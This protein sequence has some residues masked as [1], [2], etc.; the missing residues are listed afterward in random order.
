[1]MTVPLLRV[2]S[3]ERTPLTA[4]SSSVTERAQCWHVIPV[5]VTV[6]RCAACTVIKTSC[7]V[8]VDHL[9]GAVRGRR[10]GCDARS[11]AHQSSDRVGGLAHLR[12]G[13]LVARPGGVHHA[14][15]HVLGEQL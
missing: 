13:L 9:A 7:G 11:G 14:P 2:M 6:V 5:T 8:G 3:T 1:M 15:G 12:V 10:V 4:L